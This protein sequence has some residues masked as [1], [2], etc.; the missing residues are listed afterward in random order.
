MD[1]RF[2]NKQIFIRAPAYANK[3]KTSDLIILELKYDSN[4]EIVFSNNYGLKIFESTKDGWIEIKEKP[5]DRIPSGNIV[6]SPWAEMPATQIVM[7]YPDLPNLQ[8]QYSLRIYVIG[9]MKGDE[10]TTKISAYTDITLS[11]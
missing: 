11:P 5:T 7:L 9:Q 6:L 4:N 8:R 10:G 1:D 3:F 2:V